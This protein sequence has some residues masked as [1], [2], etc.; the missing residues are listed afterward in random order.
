VPRNAEVVRQW[1]ILRSIEAAHY[2]LTV[3]DMADAAGVHTRTIYR[4]LLALQEAGFPL[5]DESRDNHTFW[6]LNTHPFKHLTQ[7]GFSLSELCALYLSR[8]L[9]ESLTGIPFQSALGEA[10][11]KFER[12]IPAKMQAY[13]QRLP[14]VMSAKATGGKVRLSAAHNRMVDQLVE[15]SVA[16]RQVRMRYF[17]LSSAREDEYLLFPIRFIYTQGAMYLRAWVPAR[18]QTLTFAAQ[19]IK[20]VSVL[21]ERFESE[22]AWDEDT[23]SRSLGPNDG[24]TVHVVLHVERELAPIIAERQYHKSQRTTS[25][26]DGSLALELDLCDDVWLR[27]FILQFGHRVQ[28]VAPVSLAREIRE[29]L[30]LTRRHYAPA[31]QVEPLAASPALFDLSAQGRLPF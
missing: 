11:G 23:F 24:P 25:R 29:E 27:S 13:L 18:Q 28:V 21:E 8:R 22:A 30:D 17:S 5:V 31:A 14:S 2:G 10:F 12:E 7:L 9:V 26:P 20:R 6:K 16:R 19:R 4:D 1:N 3:H 15:A